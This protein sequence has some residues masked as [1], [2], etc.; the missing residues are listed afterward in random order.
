MLAHIDFIFETGAYDRT[1]VV[2]FHP[3]PGGTRMVFACRPMHSAKWQRLAM[4]GWKS[5]LDK[6]ARALAI[7]PDSGRSQT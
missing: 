5:S 2:E 6:L 7:Y 4:L 3:F 1:D